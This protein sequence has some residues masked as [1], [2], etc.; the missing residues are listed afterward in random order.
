MAR[1]VS[2]SASWQAVRG[3]VPAQ[4]PQGWMRMML[5][6]VMLFIGG[7][8]LWL[9][10]EFFNG[11]NGFVQRQHPST[12][13]NPAAWVYGSAP[14]AAFPISGLLVNS[15][16]PNAVHALV[17]VWTGFS[18]VITVI[19]SVTT[20]LGVVCMALGAGPPYNPGMLPLFAGLA[21]TSYRF[22]RRLRHCART[23]NTAPAQLLAS[24]WRLGRQTGVI[25]AFISCA[26]VAF[27]QLLDHS[28]A[29][30]MPSWAIILPLAPL[31]YALVTTT[32]RRESLL[33]YIA[34]L[35]PRAET[36]LDTQFDKWLHLKLSRFD[37]SVLS[38]LTLYWAL[39]SC[40]SH[41]HPIEMMITIC[42]SVLLIFRWNWLRPSEYAPRD[43]EAWC[44]CLIL[45]QAAEACAV[46]IGSP[47][48]V[49]PIVTPRLAYRELA[50]AINL[51]I[52]LMHGT[53]PIPERARRWTVALMEVLYLLW[54]APALRQ[55]QYVPPSAASA[56][57]SDGGEPSYSMYQGGGWGGW[58]GGGEPSYSVYE[59]RPEHPC[60]LLNGELNQAYLT[61]VGGCC[62]SF[63][64]GIGAVQ[65]FVHSTLKPV[66]TSEKDHQRLAADKAR[67]LGE[68]GPLIAPLIAPLMTT[69]YR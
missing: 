37:A 51:L 58:G 62:V 13:F 20:L 27:R 6:G 67:H 40:L 47:D 35:E 38:V 26:H 32:E 52:G 3:W 25:I 34:T 4:R 44:V 24:T 10:E 39:Q 11:F 53:Q 55:R 2:F 28:Y 17:A 36:D 14:I 42:L 63:T 15:D 43:G 30:P 64:L 21:I 29:K 66:W 69:D 1:K 45:W 46:A 68:D 56:D 5:V 59:R 8:T 19:H 50:F 60:R 57:G 31:L 33:R 54:L 16:T 49:L 18:F 22:C 41:Y 7:E 12:S 61:L 65:L 48:W 9:F 23:L